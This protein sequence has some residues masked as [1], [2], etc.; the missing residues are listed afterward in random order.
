MAN[1]WMLQQ[2]GILPKMDTNMVAM[3]GI[4]FYIGLL[5]PTYFTPCVEASPLA[6]NRLHHEFVHCIERGACRFELICPFTLDADMSRCFM[7]TCQ[8]IEGHVM[9]V[10]NALEYGVNASWHVVGN[11]SHGGRIDMASTSTRYFDTHLPVGEAHS[12]SLTVDG[13][14]VSIVLLAAANTA[15]NAECTPDETCDYLLRAC[16]GVQQGQQE[17]TYCTDYARHCHGFAKVDEER[18]QACIPSCLD[19]YYGH[20]FQN[21]GRENVFDSYDSDLLVA[22]LLELRARGVDLSK[23]PEGVNLSDEGFDGSNDRRSSSSSISAGGGGA[24]GFDLCKL[25]HCDGGGEGYDH[26]PPAQRVC[27]D[28]TSGLV[29]VGIVFFIL[30]VVFAWLVARRCRANYRH[31]NTFTNI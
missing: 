7:E 20:F 17:A 1:Y 29:I 5:Y 12:V 11:T 6:T 4:L 13:Q 31:G 25:T 21:M 26:C 18:R 22:I 23:A 2:M 9:A 19:T 28:F 8:P 14:D 24:G 10:H 16:Y 15:S 27:R 30:L 3:V